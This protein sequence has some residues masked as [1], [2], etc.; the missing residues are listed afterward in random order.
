MKRAVAIIALLAIVSIASTP[1][2]YGTEFAWT[3]SSSD[4]S[5]TENTGLPANG[6]ATLYL[7]LCGSGEGM[8]SAEFDLCVNDNLQLLAFTPA[9]GFLNAGGA[10]NLLLA[11][12]GC[13]IGPVVAGDILVLDLGGD[14]CLC[15][16]AANGNNVTVE[17]T[18]LALIPNQYRG[19][20]SFGPN[21]ESPQFP[22]LCGPVSVDD[23]SWGSIKSLYR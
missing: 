10:S 22:N 8:A 21:C 15:P 14:I 7:W 19:Y 2:A 23:D 11:A 9:T 16:A 12:A 4:I 13:P 1:I 20:S 18:T 3:I 5:P 17:C 6:I